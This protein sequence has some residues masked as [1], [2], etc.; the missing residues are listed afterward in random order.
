MEVQITPC[1]EDQRKPIPT[2]DSQLGFGRIFTD[3][4]FRMSYEPERGWHDPRIVPFGPLSL[5][6]ASMVLHYGQEVFEGLKAYRGRDGG[7]RLFRHRDNFERLNRSCERLVI[8]PLDVDLMVEATRKLVLLDREWIPGSPGCSLYIRPTVIA[9]DPYVG[10]APSQTYLCFIII[11]PV[12]AYYPE[13]FNPV[14]IWASSEYVRAV[15]GGM[16]EAKTGGN[17]AGS[18]KAQM[19]AREEGYAQVLW[20]DALERRYVEEVGTMNIF[21]KID[22]EVVTSPLTG[23]I[24]PGITRDSVLRLL[25]HWGIPTQE[26]RLS[27]DEIFEAGKEGALEEVFGSGTAAIVTPVKEIAYKGDRLTVG[28]GSTGP[29]ARRLYETIL[30]IQYGEGDDPFGWCE[31]ID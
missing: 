24:L 16:G 13:G 18:L 26:R 20:L 9:T 22:G 14:G 8:P 17:Y 23:S 2:D 27:I 30:A 1:R 12:G 5:S 4:M 6:P 25:A 10:V 21:F 15:R 7:V 31:R 3:H 19:A 29:L 28:D 11:G